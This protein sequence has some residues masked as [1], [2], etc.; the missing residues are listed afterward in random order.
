MVRRGFDM[1]VII[2]GG[3]RV[4]TGLAKA[5]RSE[6]KDVVLVDNS[7][8]AVKNSQGMDILVIH[9]DITQRGKFIEAGI[10]SAQVYVAATNSD[11]RNILSCALAKHVHKERTKGDGELMTICRVRNPIFVK[12]YESGKLAKWAGVDH[13]V[14]PVDGAIERLMSGLKSSSLTEV[15]PFEAD[16]F[17]VE[18]N[19][20]SEAG[21]VVHR[22]LRDS[23]EK[24]EGG[25]P[26]IVGLK[27]DGML[28]KVPTA[29]D[30]ILPNDRVAIATAGEASFN[31]ILRIFGHEAV[32]FPDKPKVIIFGAGLIGV[33]L[34]KAWLDADGSV[35]VVERDLEKANN[36]AG[37]EIGSR[38][39]IEIIHGD[40][41][42]KG[43]LSEIEISSH[44]IAISALDDDNASIAAALLASDMGVERTGL[45]LYDADLVNVVRR[46]GIT[47][48][49]DRKRVAIDT[50]LARI[51]TE[52]PGPYAV[53][54]TVPDVVGICL[55]IKSENKFAGDTIENAGLP[56]YCKVAFIQRQNIHNEWET[57]RPSPQKTLLE[58][59]RL[60]IF[61]PPDRVD[62][63]EKKFKV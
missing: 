17:I 32:D 40:H 52:L 12:E 58:G 42:D 49:V 26:L 4:G 5:L 57:M 50:I 25:M 6:D 61:L 60:T 62:D 33:R 13:V 24:V 23:G 44:D 16:A 10:E 47:F 37:S 15:I 20:K 51:H 59:D 1:R 55:P 11:E 45:I 7:A 53:L 30:Q 28:G 22:T 63:L 43:L 2:G 38:K 36:L 21:G 8:R 46:M 48:S 27:R 41:L 31:R 14:H 54:S 35:T 56:D 29:D 3:G 9:G 18:L 39:G 34:A 19:V